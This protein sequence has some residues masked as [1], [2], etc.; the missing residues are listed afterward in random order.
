MQIPLIDETDE[1][2][3][4]ARQKASEARTRSLIHQLV[5][6]HHL[7]CRHTQCPFGTDGQRLLITEKFT[8]E[9]AAPGGW[10]HRNLYSYMGWMV[11]YLVHLAVPEICL[12]EGTGLTSAMDGNTPRGEAEIKAATVRDADGDTRVA[13]TV[14]PGQRRDHALPLICV[15]LSEEF[16]V[17]FRDRPIV[18]PD[19]IA[20][21]ALHVD[22]VY[23]IPLVAYPEPV[24]TFVIPGQPSGEWPIRALQTLLRVDLSELSILGLVGLC[25][26]RSILD[27]PERVR[28]ALAFVETLG[29]V[30]GEAEVRA[31]RMNPHRLLADAEAAQARVSLNARVAEA[32]AIRT[33]REA[34]DHRAREQADAQRALLERERQLAEQR[35][36]A[37]RT[38]LAFAF[39]GIL[40]L[41]AGFPISAVDMRWKYGLRRDTYYP[42]NFNAAAR[43]RGV[44]VC[45]EGERRRIRSGAGVRERRLTITERRGMEAFLPA[46]AGLVHRAGAH[47]FAR[48]ILQRWRGRAGDD[49]VCARA[50]ALLAEHVDSSGSPG[51]V[52]QPATGPSM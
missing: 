9:C 50:L 45:A 2:L 48:E 3:L 46:W 11:E 35:D 17:A 4:T 33:L 8:P 18:L 34:A 32:I 1:A 49:H 20:E 47:P 23:L 27:S 12:H 7:F 51:P 36:R 52:S 41:S 19:D 26:I 28:V 13:F 31:Y 44:A 15:A 43:A 22:A 39:L 38:E 37:L 10:A 30:L 21:I 6:S 29:S 16:H 40:T 5:S 42:A 24:R 25:R 14:R